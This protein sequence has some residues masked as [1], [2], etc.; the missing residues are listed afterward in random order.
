[1]LSF[2]H[3][4]QIQS[5]MYCKCIVY[6]QYPEEE[7]TFYWKF[8]N[9]SCWLNIN[10]IVNQDNFFIFYRIETFSN[11][12][13][14]TYFAVRQWF[15]CSI[16]SPKYGFTL[17]QGVKV[18]TQTCFLKQLPSLFFSFLH[19]I[20]NKCMGSETLH[21]F[22]RFRKGLLQ[23]MMF[24]FS[25]DPGPVKVYHCIMGLSLYKNCIWD[26]CPFDPIYQGNNCFRLKYLEITFTFYIYL[27]ISWIEATEAMESMGL[28]TSWWRDV[29]QIF[30]TS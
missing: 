13:V 22:M 29:F 17:L 25:S 26:I 18:F 10:H 8:P 24:P 27:G 2:I 19:S 4:L 5:H 3:V 16:I 28:L 14:C 20:G 15:P 30:G 7:N 9:F 11:P 23:F 6:G 21:I 12:S 1:M